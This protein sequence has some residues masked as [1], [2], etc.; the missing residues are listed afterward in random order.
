M[1]DERPLTAWQQALHWWGMLRRR[2]DVPGLTLLTATIIAIGIFSLTRNAA[3]VGTLLMAPIALI[4]L[5][6]GWVAGLLVGG[7]AALLTAPYLQGQESLV[8]PALNLEVW[9]PLGLC[10]LALGVLTGL[11]GDLARRRQHEV[12]AEMESRLQHAQAAAERYE[13]LL[14]EMSQG[15]AHLLRMNEE[16][17]LLNGIAT[18]VNSSLDMAR[19]MDTAMTQLGALMRV[20]GLAVYWTSPAGDALALEVARPEPEDTPA[21]VIRPG[22]ALLWPAIH[23]QR[24]VCAQLDDEPR[25][26]GIS[27]EARSLAAVPLR[28]GARAR[29]VLV[30]SRRNGEAFNDDDANFLGSLARVLGLAIENARLFA[31]AQELSL[32]DELTGLGNRRLFNLRLGA[33]IARS[34][35]TGA[36]L[37][38]V[39]L[40]LDFFKRINDQYGHPAGDEVLKQFAALVQ[41]DIR[42]NDLFCRIGG[43][44]FALMVVDAVVLEAL[45]IAQRICRHIGET[46]FV[47]DDGTTFSMTVSAGVAL[48]DGSIRSVEDFA[49]VAD[50]ALYTAKANGRNRVEVFT[51]DASVPLPDPVAGEREDDVPETPVRR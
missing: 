34:R 47:L 50:R 40:D 4:A 32:S 8:K 6:R 45:A 5:V 38:L 20:D 18:A 21:A 3:V 14:E 33:E 31:R 30:L 9:A 10:Y 24:P 28:V 27:P 51:P 42:G 36:P 12:V 39:M 29:G 48:L 19:I 46:P 43:E 17:A 1:A 22:D 2:V 49:V 23:A 16:L 37:C 26:P 15:H 13:A 25:P 7:T 41:H 44:E 11:R 35:A